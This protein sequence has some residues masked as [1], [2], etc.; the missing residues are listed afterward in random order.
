MGQKFQTQAIN[1]DILEGLSLKN[2]YNFLNNNLMSILTPEEFGFLRDV[3]RFCMRYEKKNE[4][5][6]GP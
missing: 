2:R 1:D 4:I 6:H 3:Q 5:T